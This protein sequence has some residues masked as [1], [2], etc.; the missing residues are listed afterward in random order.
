MARFDAR[1]G[2]QISA[3]SLAIELL[4]AV[5]IALAVPIVTR[6]RE[7][8]KV[9]PPFEKMSLEG[10]GPVKE[11][12]L[13][14]VHGGSLHTT[15]EWTGR[16]AIV[17]FF[18]ATDCPV[19]NGY[20]PEMTRLA[21]AFGPRGIVFRGIHADPDVT[22]AVR[23]GPRR[24]VRFALPDSARP[25]SERRP[26]G[27]CQ[28]QRPRPSSSCPTARSSIEA[29]STTAIR[30]TAGTGPRRVSTSWRTRSRQSSATRCRS[31]PGPN[32]SAVRLVPRAK[33]RAE[34]HET[35]TFAKHVAPILWNNCAR[36][37]RPGDGR[38]RSRS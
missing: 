16:P 26:A 35:I 12:A 2:S 28:R 37:H 24:R 6:L 23:R 30:P 27:G 29:G 33:T 1:A 31:S 10:A 32:R 38:R 15:A 3:G 14:D 19:S 7:P 18:I 13:R 11:F 17:L 34:E 5:V 8:P 9:E 25:G 4:G 21:K 22:A 20:A 36:C